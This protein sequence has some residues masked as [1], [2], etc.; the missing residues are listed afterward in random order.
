MGVDRP[1]HVSHQ[2]GA[3]V[4][5][6]VTL[7]IAVWLT[8]A[9][10]AFSLI[11]S[12]RP[13]PFVIGVTSLLISPLVAMIA[14]LLLATVQIMDKLSSASEMIVMSTAGVSRVP[15]APAS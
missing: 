9:T 2:M 6:L 12:H 11:T 13:T 15:P 5:T 10:D 14:P 8:Q 1:A 7:T 3:F 4:I